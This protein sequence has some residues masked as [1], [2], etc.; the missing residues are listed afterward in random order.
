MKRTQVRLDE[1]M[2]HAVRRKAFEERR[3]M[4]A[5]IRELIARSVGTTP[6]RS[7]PRR[8]AEFSFIGAGRSKQGRLSPVSE[9]HDEALAQASRK[10]P[11]R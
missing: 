11:R 6:A 8:L 9:K 3:S 4:A 1:A 7:R 10:V 2:Y 5:V